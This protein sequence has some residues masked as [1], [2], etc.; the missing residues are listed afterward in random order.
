MN[1]Y[2]INKTAR[3]GKKMINGRYYYDREQ[4]TDYVKGQ[5]EE[6]I[7]DEKGTII[8]DDLIIDCSLVSHGQGVITSVGYYQVGT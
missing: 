4:T 7:K 5:V 8:P 1:S 2:Y 6:I 3:G